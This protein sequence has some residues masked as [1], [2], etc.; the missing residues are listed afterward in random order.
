MPILSPTPRN[1]AEN[2]GPFHC[3][4][5]PAECLAMASPIGHASLSFKYTSEKWRLCGDKDKSSTR[6]RTEDAR[7]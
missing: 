2:V 4:T 3:A 5:E 6:T 7:F 1:D